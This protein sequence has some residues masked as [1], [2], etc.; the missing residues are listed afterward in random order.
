MKKCILL[1]LSAI[2]FSIGSY[3]QT[4]ITGSFT[5][6]TTLTEANSPYTI[7]N[8]ID[9]NA[10]VT[11]TIEKNVII[12][13]NSG[14]YLQVFGTLNAKGVLFTANSSTAKGFWDGIYVSYEGSASVGNVNLDSCTVE[15]AGN[16]Y[17][18]KGQLTLK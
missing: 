13:F 1:F 18:R 5:A 12:K 9:I 11:V 3:A 15:Y 8:S 14:R 7:V 6:N 2:L 17:V 10:G 4:N 16:L